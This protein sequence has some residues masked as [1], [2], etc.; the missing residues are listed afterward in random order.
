MPLANLT[1]VKYLSELRTLIT[2]PLNG[3]V[4]YVKFHRFM[5]DEGGGFFRF[6]SG[7][8]RNDNDGTIIQVGPEGTPPTYK[9]R[10]IRKLDGHIN[11]AYFG[12]TAQQQFDDGM[13]IQRAI[14]YAADTTVR[15]TTRT[16]Y[17]PAGQYRINHQLTLRTGVSLIGDSCGDV[18]FRAGYEITNA[19]WMITMGPG[20]IEGCNIANI[21]FIGDASPDDGSNMGCMLFQAVATNNYG[22]MDGGMWGCTFKN[23]N[24]RNFNGGGIYLMG[25]G[26][27]QINTY[28]EPNQLC[29]FENVNINRQ[30]ANTHALLMNGEQGQMTFINCGFG[31]RLYDITYVDGDPLKGRM[32]FKALKGMNMAITNRGYVQTAVVSF[33]NCT[34]QDAEYGAYIAYAESITF[35]TCW[36]ENTDLAVSVDAGDNRETT[37]I[38]A[39][40]SRGINILN[41]RF[42]NASGFGSLKCDNKNPS[43]RCITSNKSTVNVYNN[44]VTVSYIPPAGT[45]TYPAGQEDP[46]TNKYFILTQSNNYGIKTIGNSF[47]DYRLG[48]TFGML[49]DIPITLNSAGNY[50]DL[51]DSRLGYVVGTASNPLIQ[52]I[53]CSILTGETLVLR[54]A[55]SF[56]IRFSDSQNIFLSYKGTI[57]LNYG[58]VA[59]F[60]KIDSL[61]GTYREMYQLISLFKSSTVV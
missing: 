44:Y 33:L 51:K 1:S 6:D 16:I 31:G 29:V 21:L 8:T 9:G 15:A 49:S 37:A 59:T 36:F 5:S 35:D 12:V 48:F 10:W 17:F 54:G 3:D 7:E 43:G 4:I 22:I 39:I 23:L 14:D 24:I 47:Q 25:G 52:T 57:T 60:I 55:N 28:N 46:F 45:T 53:R 56:P 40:P 13:R 58:D 34:F 61:G 30:T 18:E 26:N 2:A 11:I 41:S 19:G 32:S 42:A 38:E 20:R 50:L 27:S